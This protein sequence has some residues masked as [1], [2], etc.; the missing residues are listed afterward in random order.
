MHADP[1]CPGIDLYPLSEQIS[2]IISILSPVTSITMTKT[3]DSI[4]GIGNFLRE[5]NLGVEMA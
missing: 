3:R 2:D 4:G 5:N 1:P